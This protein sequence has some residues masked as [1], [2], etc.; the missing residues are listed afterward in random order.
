MDLSVLLDPMD[1]PRIQEILDGLGHLGRVA[2]IRE[3]DRETQSRLWD[4]AKGFRPVTLTDFVPAGTPPLTE[5][6]HHGKNTLP[7]FSHFQKRFCKPAEGGPTDALYGYNHQAMSAFTGPG[8][9]VARD[10]KEGEV[11]I[12][13]TKI[14][15]QK[16]ASWPPILPNEAKLGRLVYAGM[17]DM[18][19]GLSSHVTIGRAFKKGESMDAWFVLCREDLT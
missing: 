8:Y 2:T 6:I 13:Y 12:D 19:R 18:M 10:D 7:L 14:P 5:V 17:V 15:S 11:A 4:A 9:Y 1:L 3:W 16:P